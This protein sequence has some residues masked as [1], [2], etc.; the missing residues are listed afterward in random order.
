MKTYQILANFEKKTCY[1]GE[2][3]YIHNGKKAAE[4]SNL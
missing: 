4:E 3:G 2:K 1:Q